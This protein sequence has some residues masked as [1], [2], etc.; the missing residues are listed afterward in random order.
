M[1]CG[2]PN[3]WFVTGAVSLMMQPAMATNSAATG[4]IGPAP[5]HL[6]AQNDHADTDL[7]RPDTWSAASP[8]TIVRGLVAPHSLDRFT[9]ADPHAVAVYVRAPQ[10]QSLP[11]WGA[12]VQSAGLPLVRVGERYGTTSEPGE[13]LETAVF[14][15]SAAIDA[16]LVSTLPNHTDRV[17]VPAGALVV[18]G[19][20]WEFTDDDASPWAPSP[21]MDSPVTCS[22]GYSACCQPGASPPTYTCIHDGNQQTLANCTGGG[23]GTVTCSINGSVTCRAGYYA[24]CDNTVDPQTFTCRQNS[25]SDAHCEGGGVGAVSCQIS[26]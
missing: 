21:G 10:Y 25:Q 20:P 2:L 14:W 16:T 8:D 17:V 22:D 19:F 18:I 12:W 15:N 4:L 13:V 24:C 1:K 23:L 6:P 11:R 9:L 7:A 26:P 3:A 5:V